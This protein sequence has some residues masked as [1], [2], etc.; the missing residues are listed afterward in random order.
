MNEYEFTLTFA[1]PENQADAEQYVDLLFNAGCDDAV[2]GTGQLG[3]VSLEF[4]RGAE[5]AADAVDSAI[6][7]V[8][9]AIPGAEL[10]EAMPD[11]VGLS[12]VADILQCSRQNI[13]KYMVNYK[14]FP[15]PA[16]SGKSQLWHLWEV[17]RF[18]KFTVP[19][20]IAD[21]AQTTFRINL[22]IQRHRFESRQEGNS[23]NV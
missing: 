2:V 1:L 10:T 5:S 17:A 15:R 20:P 12:D 23:H 21:I 8:T 22:D 6:M 3:S 11:L 13:R 9:Q 16:H 18:S 19:E 4:M 14:E 7:N